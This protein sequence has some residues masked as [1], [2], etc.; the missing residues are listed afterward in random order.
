MALSGRYADAFPAGYRE[1]YPAR[2]AVHDIEQIEALGSGDSLRMSLYIPL[3]ASLGQLRFK[4]FRANA[5]VP[6][7]ASLPMLERMGLRVLD[8]RPYRI[9]PAEGAPVWLHDFGLST[10]SDRDIDLG[11]V[12]VS[13][14]HWPFLRDRR[15]DAY[16][17]LTKRYLD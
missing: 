6:L 10:G 5:P 4:I 17:E 1:D 2:A 11:K 3:E 15:I 7:S 16:G 12:D 13:R 8:E 9:Q 14:T